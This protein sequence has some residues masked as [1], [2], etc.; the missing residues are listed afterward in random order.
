MSDT[1]QYLIVER[2]SEKK[3]FPYVVLQKFGRIHWTKVEAMAQISDL[4]TDGI[5]A[6]DLRVYKEV[7]TE[8]V[9]TMK[10]DD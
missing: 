8:I 2:K 7:N 1:E 4:I 6:S 5:Q 10:I 9:T 3:T